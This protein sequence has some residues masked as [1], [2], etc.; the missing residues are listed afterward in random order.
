MAWVK[1][2]KYAMLNGNHA[3]SKA[4][5]KDEWIYTLWQV[6]IK[7][8]NVKNQICIGHYKSFK[9]AAEFIK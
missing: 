3:I 4:F 7:G 5:V 9:E 1:W 8:E 6:E 2:G